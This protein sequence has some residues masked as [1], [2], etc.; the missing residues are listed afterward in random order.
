MTFFERRQ[1][2]PYSEFVTRLQVTIQKITERRQQPQA[3]GCYK[4]IIRHFTTNGRI[5]ADH[6]ELE[7]LMTLQEMEPDVQR[8]NRRKSNAFWASVT[9]KTILKLAPEVY[10]EKH[11]IVQVTRNLKTSLPKLTLRQ[12]N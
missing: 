5:D 2:E 10:I 12:Q 7:E 8:Y 9:W 3:S 4:E 11:A 1:R 6:D